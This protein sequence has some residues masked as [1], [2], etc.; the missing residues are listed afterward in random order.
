MFT[1]GQLIVTLVQTIGAD[2]QDIEHTLAP[3]AQGFIDSIE[4]LP[5]QGVAYTV[6]IKTDA[7]DE[8]SHI[9][10]VFDETDGDI[11]QF[12]APGT[13]H[14]FETTGEA[15]DATQCDDNIA[16]GD[17]LLI[18]REGVVAIA[19]TWPLAVTVA[20]G[21]LHTPGDGLTLER[22]LERRAALT[23][24]AAAKAVAAKHG[25]AVRE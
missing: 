16:D 8:E 7:D 2:H 15:Y 3:G 5:N 22:S 25:F 10:N 14:E 19:D 11:A 24:I 4:V 21:K 13:I 18:A 9:V 1:K 23:G 6:V 12:I 17:V 20:A